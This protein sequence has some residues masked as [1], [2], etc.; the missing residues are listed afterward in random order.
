MNN[1]LIEAKDFLMSKIFKIYKNYVPEHI[2]VGTNEKYNIVIMAEQ[3]LNISYTI[4][5]LFRER[6]ISVDKIHDKHNPNEIIYELFADENKMILL[7]CEDLKTK[8]ITIKWV[9][10][11]WLYSA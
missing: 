3:L 8:D 6:I 7:L 9:D 5:K 2:N 10:K 4:P 11:L 1:K